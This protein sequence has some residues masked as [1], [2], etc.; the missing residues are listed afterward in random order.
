MRFARVLVIFIT[1]ILLAAMLPACGCGGKKAPSLSF[2]SGGETPVINYSSYK[3]I[4]PV[5]NPDVPVVVIYA[6]GTMITKQGPYEFTTGTLSR[7]QLNE[8]L[9]SLRDAGF[10]GFKEEYGAGQAKA[11]GSTQTITVVLESGTYKVSVAG[12]AGPAGWSDIVD[13]VTGA[14]ASAEKDFVPSSVILYSKEESQA[15]QGAAVVPWP[16]QASDLAGA[17]VQ[18]GKQL[19]GDSAA[20]AWKALQGVFA[21]GGAGSD[22]YWTADGKNYTYVYARPEL[23]GVKQ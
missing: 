9:E 2:P 7:D 3:A 16:G 6:D 13:T 18:D 23:P 17:V 20:S 15:P 4:S 22:T 5:Y 8:I 14:K 12:G 1:A 21:Q 10:F 19:E 11:G